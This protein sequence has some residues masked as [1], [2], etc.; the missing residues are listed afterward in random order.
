MATKSTAAPT[1]PLGARSPRTRPQPESSPQQGQLRLVIDES[2]TPWR[3]DDTTREIGRRGVAR[4][5]EVL[6]TRPGPLDHAA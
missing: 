4:A 5:R 1:K 3:L 6:R 2:P